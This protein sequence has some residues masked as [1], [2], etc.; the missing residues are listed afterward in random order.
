MWEKYCFLFIFERKIAEF[1]GF[2]LVIENRN[3]HLQVTFGSN[4]PILEETLRD[5]Q[6]YEI[7]PMLMCKAHALVKPWIFSESWNS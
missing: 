1:V 3:Q 5:E 6:N 7:F 4:V 2:K